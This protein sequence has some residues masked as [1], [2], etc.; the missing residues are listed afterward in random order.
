MLSAFPQSSRESRRSEVPCCCGLDGDCHPV[1]KPIQPEGPPPGRRQLSRRRLWL[2]RFTAVVLIPLLLF[3]ALELTLRLVGYGHSTSFFVRTRISGEEFYVPND[4]FGFRFFPPEIARTPFAIR[5]RAQKPAGTYRIFLFGESAAQGDPDPTFGVGRY[6]EVLLRER[7]PGREFEVVCVAMTAINSHAILPIARECARLEGDLWIVYMGNNEVVG[8]FGAGTVFGPQAPARTLIQASLALKS[9]RTGQMLEALLARFG[10]SGKSQQAWRGL[11][12][13]K[14]HQVRHDDPKRQQAM[15]NFAGNLGDVLAVARGRRIPVLL[16]TVASNLKD[17]APFAS[18]HRAGLSEADLATWQQ[19]FRAGCVAQQQQDYPKALAAFATAATVDAQ[20][21]EL[22]FRVGTCELALTNLAAARTNF[23][24]ARDYDA[25]AFRADAGINQHI[26]QAARQ[27]GAAEVT[28][29]DAAAE[30]ARESSDGIPGEEFFYE[31]VHLNFA[32]NYRLAHLFAEHLAGQLPVNITAK[33]KTNWAEQA[34]CEARLAATLWDQCRVW[35]A[36]YSRVSEPPFT[37]QLNDV[38]RA[39]RYMA[40]LDQFRSQMDAEAQ[41]QARTVYREALDAAPD[42]PCLRGNHAQLLGEFGDFAAA[43]KEQERVCELLPQSPEVFYKAGV[44]L[45]RQNVM[46]RATEQFKHALALRAD[47]VPALNELG[48]IL[49]YQQKLAEAEQC[50]LNAIQIN[51]GYMESHINLGFTKQSAGG[52]MAEALRQYQLAAQLQ[53]EG[54]A[55]YFSKGVE[56]ANERRSADAVKL[57]QATVW[58]N[59]SFWQA[60]YLLGVELALAGQVDEAEAQFAGVVRLRPDFAKAHLNLGVAL[61][62]RRKLDE[63]LVEFQRVL[64]LVSTN[65]LAQRSIEAIQ[66]M[67]NRGL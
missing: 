60:R 29:V 7:Y 33:Q 10:K 54:P 63:A 61:A 15:A 46:E 5:V 2:F 34:V 12:M 57:F 58:M 26:V 1:T 37:E 13:F 36:N 25:L 21:A 30:L 38:P 3:G 14:D 47:Y 35:Q 11:Q 42:D 40:R 62:K 48:L 41:Q 51:P 18:L 50:F 6:L 52:Q 24:L 59:P 23:A 49:A 20:F 28:L 56:S 17:C 67:K 9:T 64:K 27:R 8:P 4:R 66:L 31:H 19:A 39:K 45:V 22:P 65:E 44:L 32:G 43:V 55:A 53:P 16:S